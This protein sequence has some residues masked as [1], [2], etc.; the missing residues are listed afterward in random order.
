MSYFE[1]DYKFFEIPYYSFKNKKIHYY[2]DYDQDL[3]IYISDWVKFVLPSEIEQCKNSDIQLFKL[4]LFCYRN[5]VSKHILDV[6]N[7]LLDC[8]PLNIDYCILLVNMN[9][10][11]N[12]IYKALDIIKLALKTYPKNGVLLSC[13]AKVYYI[14]NKKDIALLYLWKG[15]LQ[16]PN[17]HDAFFTYFNLIF[18]DNINLCI[19]KINMLANTNDSFIPQLFLA[20]LALYENNLDKALNIYSKVL[21]LSSHTS[22]ILTEITKKLSLFGYHS[23]LILLT[24]PLYDFEKMPHVIGLRLLNAYAFCKQ[25]VKG[26]ALLHKFMQLNN[27]CYLKYLLNISNLLDTFKP[28]LNTLYNSSSYKYT[29]TVFDTPI[30][31][32]SLDNPEWLLNN[33]HKIGTIGILPFINFSNSNIFTN[34]Y[35]EDNTSRLARSLPLYIGEKIHYET[36]FNFNYLLPLAINKGPIVKKSDYSENY[37]NSISKKNNTPILI[38]GTIDKNSKKYIF[39]INIYDSITRKFKIFPFSSNYNNFGKNIN[40]MLHAALSSISGLTFNESNF[41]ESPLNNQLYNYLQL[42]S[43]SLTQTLISNK[44][45]DVNSILGERNIINSYFNYALNNKDNISKIL[46]LSGLSKSKIYNKNIYLEPKN[47]ILKFFSEN[48]TILDKDL[49]IFLD[50]LYNIQVG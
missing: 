12:L 45:I 8:K 2:N 7:S 49:S 21:N 37:L 36:N 34:I 23:E 11:C 16:N 20:N 22:F 39:N 35:Y 32:Y 18:S 41:Y 30:W 27:P 17:Q 5:G 10:Q 48:Q 40:S 14:L 24:E 31:Y 4:S 28:N 3:Y 26:E 1:S 47:K 29:I 46:L 38:F 15:L 13:L 25:C 19:K 43:Y 9:L 33:D 44:L 42:L 6:S 50:K